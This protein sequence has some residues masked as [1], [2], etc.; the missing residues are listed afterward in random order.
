MNDYQIETKSNMP[1]GEFLTVH[2]KAEELSQEQIEA[3][4]R[5][6]ITAMISTKCSSASKAKYGQGPWWDVVVRDKAFDF[7][8]TDELGR[9]KKNVL[10]KE[11]AVAKLVADGVSPEEII[12]M[13]LAMS[14]KSE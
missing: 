9:A 2:V 5:A 11:S 1:A 6:R 10:T 14:S 3:L 12:A 13:V 7:V 4:A 8:V